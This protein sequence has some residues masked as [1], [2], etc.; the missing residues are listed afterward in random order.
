[1]LRELWYSAVSD[2][3]LVQSPELFSF[4]TDFSGNNGSVFMFKI[5]HHC[6]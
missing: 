6:I 1:M 3:K 5:L 4:T 2:D